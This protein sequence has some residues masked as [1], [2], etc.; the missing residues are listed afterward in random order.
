MTLIDAC[1]GSHFL[2]TR[3]GYQI[4]HKLAWLELAPD[5]STAP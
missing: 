4:L 5:K 3:E 2:E 1:L